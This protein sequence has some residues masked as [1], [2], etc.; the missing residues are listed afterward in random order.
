MIYF[1]SDYVEGAH[2]NILNRLIETN[3][4]QTPGY[5]ED[6]YCQSAKKK[7]KEII[8]NDNADVHFLVGG[9]QTNLTVIASALRP[10]QGV[11]APE[12]GHIAV[13]ET[14]AI[15]ATGHKVLTLPSVDGKISG[16]QVDE[17]VNAH[18]ASPTAEHEIQPGMVYVSFST[19]SGTL[20]SNQQ[21][22]DLYSVCKKHNIPL[23]VDGARMGYGLMSDACDMT[24]A[25]IASLCDV[26]YIGGTKC[27]ALFGEAVVITND[28]LKKDF[29]Y[30]IKQRGGMLAKGWLLGIQF[31]TLFTDDLYFKI[32]KSAINH[33]V[34][35][36]SAFESRGIKMFGSSM[37]N[38]QFP[39]L[40][41]T[42][43]KYLEKNNVFEVW[44]KYDESHTIVR[45]CTSWATTETNVASLIKDIENMPE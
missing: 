21:L 12:E 6:K 36:R 24:I 9:T 11:I 29:R 45:F 38:Q 35:I 2:P 30:M 39:I 23:F 26:F 20:Y 42:Q 4:D 37:T 14:G 5:G 7:I 8:K 31:D 3:F 34:K 15:E 13:H 33:A 25:D 44:G 1:T 10:Y 27:G 18:F 43:I 41:D 22:S 40:T 32:C 28:A 19:E 16:A 17:Y